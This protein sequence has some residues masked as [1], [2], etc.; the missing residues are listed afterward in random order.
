MGQGGA[1]RPEVMWGCVGLRWGT[2]PGLQGS[3]SEGI[4]VVDASRGGSW[5]G[6]A[7]TRAVGAGRL[8]GRGCRA[9][10]AHLQHAIFGH[11]VAEYQNLIKLETILCVSP[12]KCLC[13]FSAAAPHADAAQRCGSTRVHMGCF[14]RV[15]ARCTSITTTVTAA[16][17]ATT[18]TA[19]ADVVRGRLHPHSWGNGVSGCGRRH[20][21]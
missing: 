6:T 15:S 14:D 3:L 4:T 11:A 10:Q 1:D 17:S 9:T 8:A 19:A 13:A 7:A 16:L 20:V 5:E 2:D 18:L 21:R 12:R